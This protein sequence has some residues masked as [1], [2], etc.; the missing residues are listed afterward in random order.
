MNITKNYFLIV[1]LVKRQS[2]LNSNSILQNVTS[3]FTQ[4]NFFRNFLI[5]NFVPRYILLASRLDSNTSNL[6]RARA[7]KLSLM[8][9]SLP[10]NEH[11]SCRISFFIIYSTVRKEEFMFPALY[12]A[13]C[14]RYSLFNFRMCKCQFIIS[15]IVN[16]QST[17]FKR[18]NSWKKQ[19]SENYALLKPECAQ[20]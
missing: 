3:I 14:L 2:V 18:I 6:S 5:P 20:F 8:Y 11:Y 17:Y 15:L 7:Q 12:R 1:M 13:P 19:F 4:P 9:H 10:L 16:T